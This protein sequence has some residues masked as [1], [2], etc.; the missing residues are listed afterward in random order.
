[1]ARSGRA[2]GHGRGGE[3]RLALSL[4]KRR[5]T[6]RPGGEERIARGAGAG[7]RRGR[8][9]TRAQDRVGIVP[10][11]RRVVLAIRVPRRH[12]LV[13]SGGS[14][15]KRAREVRAAPRAGDIGAAGPARRAQWTPSRALWSARDGPR[16]DLPRRPVPERRLAVLQAQA[17]AGAALTH[18]LAL[19]LLA[20]L[21]SSGA[22]AE[23]YRASSYVFGTIVQITVA[24]SDPAR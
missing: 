5:R 16:R 17:P 4:R 19:A 6:H 18:Q 23:E 2:S 12:R 11:P 1:A 24:D 14:L 21:A 22:R 8:A 15:R 20:A 13:L 7:Y 3:Q 10:E 9:P